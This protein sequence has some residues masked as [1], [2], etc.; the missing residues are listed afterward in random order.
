MMAFALGLAAV[1]MANGIHV[2]W[3][4]VAVSLPQTYSGNVLVVTP[5]A[6][7]YIR[8][9]LEC[10]GD[11][12]SGPDDYD[13]VKRKIIGDRDM[14]LYDDGG[15]FDDPGFY[16]KKDEKEV[17]ASVKAARDFIWSHWQQK[18]RGYLVIFRSSIDAG[19]DAH[20]FIEP[21]RHGNWQISAYWERQYGVA[22][23]HGDVDKIPPIRSV[24]RVRAAD[25]N[26]QADPRLIYLKM[27]DI[28]GDD[29]SL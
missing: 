17:E 27:T 12:A 15:H 7:P 20:I 9:P 11:G 14:S 16:P 29:F 3:Q 28:K 23:C 25:E 4:Q 13:W 10:P 21:D 8:L 18:K 6:G 22:S 5:T 2:A 24:K 1:Y 19:S 26:W